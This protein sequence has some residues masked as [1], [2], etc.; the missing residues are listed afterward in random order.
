MQSFSIFECAPQKEKKKQVRKLDPRLLQPPH[1]LGIVAPSRSG[2]TN[3]IVNLLIRD[4][5]YCQYF[6]NIYIWVP[7]YYD[8]EKWNLVHLPEECIFTEFREEDLERVVEN[9]KKD[10]SKNSLFI[11]D[12]CISEKGLYS[13]AH[14]T[15]INKL[16]FRG[17]HWNISLWFVSQSYK[18]ITRGFRLNMTGWI[19]FTVPNLQELH[20][21]AEEHAGPLSRQEFIEMFKKATEKP[22]SFLF[23]NYQQPEKI[24]SYW[25]NFEYPILKNGV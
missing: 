14:A 13:S 10:T 9:V 1:R 5:F 7:T 6:H 20:K 4:E 16:V 11:F 18:A 17:R 24:L 2:K 21:I 22:F 12:D 3:L 8:D 23:I 15:L 19:F 25:Q